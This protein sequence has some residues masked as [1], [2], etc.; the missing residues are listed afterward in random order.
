MDSIER[1]GEKRAEATGSLCHGGEGL[2]LLH[3][4]NTFLTKVQQ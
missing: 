2:S 4:T 1:V 3:I